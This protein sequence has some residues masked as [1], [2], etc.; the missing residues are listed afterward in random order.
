M[1][2]AQTRAAILRLRR[3]GHGQRFIARTVGVSRISVKRVLASGQDEP[4]PKERPVALDPH[5]DLVRELH[6]A[7][8]GN[9]VRVH[10][11]LLARG[12]SVPY[13]TLTRFCRDHEIGQEP[14]KRSGRY[15]FAPGEEMQHDTSPH[16]VPVGGAELRLQCASLVLCF[17]RMRFAQCYRRWTRF[18]AKVFLTLAFQYFEGV[19]RRAMLD[20]STV[21]MMGGTGKNAV[22]VPEMAAFAK[23]FDFA[24]VAH[25]A[26]DK[27]RSARVEGPFGHIETNFYP[28][29]TFTDLADLNRQLV[30]WCDTYNGTYHRSFRAIPREL[31]QVERFALKPLPAFVPEVTEIHPRKVDVEGYVTLHTNRY[32]MPE[33]LIGRLVAVHET[34]D[35]VTVYDGHHKVVTHDK[36][37]DGAGE[38]I[39]LPEHRGSWSRRHPAPPSPEERAL[40]TASPA[41]ALLCDA[42][43]ARH[44]GQARKAI[45]TLHRIW[46]DYPE[47]AVAPAIGR[48]LEFGLLDLARIE[49]MVLGCVVGDFFRLP[50]PDPENPNG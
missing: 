14:K 4:T 34:L 7:C 11:M 1:L 33:R 21:I 40:R 27:N 35:R 12:V 46:T 2:D 25:E 6:R 9:V 36:V 19:A 23:H 5:L 13:S 16:T 39:T 38:R 28:G 43:R 44:G 10:E 37:E 42:L 22:P 15:D 30:D 32:S 17:S 24:F 31:Y 8:R 3:E 18:H 50:P 20:N 26:G 49:K 45:R 41:L 48:A 47:D 29:R